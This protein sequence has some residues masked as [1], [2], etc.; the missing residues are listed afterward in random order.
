MVLLPSM[1][2]IDGIRLI[3]KKNIKKI[4][5][6]IEGFSVR[7]MTEF[8]FESLVESMSEPMS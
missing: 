3:L 7:S 4:S 8:M 5:H 2:A 6:I 1:D